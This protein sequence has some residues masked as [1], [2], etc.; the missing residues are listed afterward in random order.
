MHVFLKYNYISSPEEKEDVIIFLT[1]FY[2]FI[3]NYNIITYM[4]L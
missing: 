4:H 1:T 2:N 3:F